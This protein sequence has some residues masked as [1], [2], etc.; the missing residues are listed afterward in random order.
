[1]TKKHFIALAHILSSAQEYDCV[2]A[3]DNMRREIARQ[4]A[5]YCRRTNERFDYNKFLKAAGL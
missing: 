5:D 1:M 3:A 2:D 4:I